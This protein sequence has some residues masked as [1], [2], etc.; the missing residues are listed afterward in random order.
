MVT[1]KTPFAPEEVSAYLAANSLTADHV[2]RIARVLAKWRQVSNGWC[3]FH[4]V[5]S[6]NTNDP[7]WPPYTMVDIYDAVTG[8][9]PCT[10][11]LTDGRFIVA[12][13]HGSIT[14]TTLKAALAAILKHS[15]APRAK[16]A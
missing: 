8:E 2:S 4:P 1:S 15:T 9:S 13:A 12:N 10:I 3:G 5:V 14:R 16:A 6:T 7:G 11:G